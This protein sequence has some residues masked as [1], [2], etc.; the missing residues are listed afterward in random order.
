MLGKSETT[1]ASSNLFLQTNSK[2]KIYSRKK[3]SGI[4]KVPDL[5]PRFPGGVVFGKT[6][7]SIP[8]KKAVGNSLALDSAIDS[9]LLSRFMPACAIIN[10]EM[11]IL[12]FRGSTSSYL[13]HSSGKASL[14]IF[15]LMRPEFSFELRNA[16][17]TAFKTDRK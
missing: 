14:N 10:K 13:S 11:E 17:H 16:I 5:M 8:A 2:F 15:K 7:K 12:Q 3:N 9:V 1:G 4:R 6:I